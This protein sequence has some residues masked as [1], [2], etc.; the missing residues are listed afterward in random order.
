MQVFRNQSKSFRQILKIVVKLNYYMEQHEKI[1]KTNF[2]IKTKIQEQMQ[3]KKFI[4]F[5]Y[6][7]K[8]KAE[9]SLTASARCSSI[10]SGGDLVL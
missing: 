9:L 7:T 1:Y 2:F 4:S 6:K 5:K 8:L 10:F 3:P